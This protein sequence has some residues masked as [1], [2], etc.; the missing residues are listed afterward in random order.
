MSVKWTPQ[1][2]KA[3]ATTGSSL[4]VSAA[5]GS[6]KTA[7]LASRCAYLVCDA[8]DPCDIDELLVVTFTNAAAEEMR[9]RIGQAIADRAAQSNDPRLHRQAMLINAAQISTIHALGSAIIRRHFHELGID[10]NFRLLDED[11]AKLLRAQIVDQ[12]FEDRFDDP[13]AT[14]F[15]RLV[16]L[17]ANG[18]PRA[19]AGTVLWLSAKLES[20]IDAPQ[21]LVE[22]RERIVESIEKP[23][24]ESHIGKAVLDILQKRI[25]TLVGVASRLAGSIAGV[26]SL[27]AYEAYVRGLQSSL[28]AWIEALQHESWDEAAKFV[29]A[30][31]APSLPRMAQSPEKIAA[32]ERING[33]RDRIKRF[34]ESSL[35]CFSEQ[36]LRDGM[37]RSLWAIE[38]ITTLA[39]EFRERYDRAKRE[40][41]SL[42]FSDLEGFALQLLREPGSNPAKPSAIAL[43]Y[44][45]Q[46]KHVLVDEYQDVNAVQDTIIALLSRGDNHFAVGDVKQSIYR[47]RQADPQRFIDRYLL[48]ARKPAPGELVLLR[49]NFRSRGALLEALNGIFASLM[50]R[51]S[52][53]VIYNDTQKL[54]PGATFPAHADGLFRGTPIEL[55]VVEKLAPGALADEM[56]ADEREAVIAASRIRTLLGR[57]GGAPAQVVQRDGST[58]PIEPRDVVILLRAMRVKAERFANILRE[59]GIPVQ[60]DSTTGFFRA[61]EV[62]DM[63]SVLELIDNARNDIALAGFLRS[64]LS[65]WMNVEDRLLQIRLAYPTSKAPCFHQALSLYAENGKDELAGVIRETLHQLD[66]WRSA[67]RTKPVAEVIWTILQDTSYLAYIRGL[68]DGA[69]RVAN[70]LHLHERARQFES[71]QRPTVGRFLEFLQSIEDEGDLGMPAAAGVAQNAVRIMSIHKSKGLEFPVVIVPDLARGHNLRDADT[72]L[73]MDDSVG[74]AA[75]V[76]DAEKEVHYASLASTLAHH[77][78]RRKQIAEELRVLYVAGTRAKEHLILIGTAK[79]DCQQEWDEYAASAEGPMPAGDVQSAGSMLDWVGPAAS[80]V[81]R[82]QPGSFE[83]TFHPA[84]TIAPAREQMRLA[85]GASAISRDIVTLQPLRNPPAPSDAARGVIERLS[86][87]YPHQSLA[88]EPAVT[89]V[90]ALTKRGKVA[91]GGKTPTIA[92]VVSFDHLLNVPAFMSE[93]PSLSATDLG[94]ITHTVLQRLDFAQSCDRTNVLQQIQRMAE[95]RFLRETEIG[96]VDLGAIEWFLST[97]IGQRMRSAPKLLRELDI[98][99]LSTIETQTQVQIDP[100]DRVMVRGR[101]DAVLVEEQGLTLVDYKTDR[102]TKQTVKQRAEFYSAQIDAYREQLATITGKSVRE[103][104]LI[105]FTPREVIPVP[106]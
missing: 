25:T 12:L 14:D 100:A 88:S 47:F 75:R 60:A 97:P 7:V 104:Y 29:C 19:L 73:L 18:N 30:F 50:T 57:D 62:G 59:S 84:T 36:Q 77:E 68:P 102:V 79:E 15:R 61:T 78:I 31:K 93:D 70:V 89:S 38:Q 67:S 63:L 87:A 99:F 94:S 65:G 28:E 55:H 24:H 66:E 82:A 13:A 48:F 33:L 8:P 37:K 64:P 81:E 92:P 16:D 69:Q 76:V 39:R 58:R 3:I 54:V 17:Y 96:A 51:E 21:W 91:P 2:Q 80:M 105:F 5:A 71:F 40:I 103:A 45:R 1:Q 86:Y 101:L 90:T 32:Q 27:P 41:G 106:G 95:R 9:K 85:R 83:R 74:V 4:L 35:F 10:P 20:V 22:R 98:S 23:I 34:L 52:A 72:R 11:E 53:E 42:D 49:E 26:G 6:G 43:E 56:E 44:Q 46:F